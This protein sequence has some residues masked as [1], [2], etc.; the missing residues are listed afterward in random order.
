M[1]QPRNKFTVLLSWDVTSKTQFP[2]LFNSWSNRNPAYLCLLGLQDS[3]EAKMKAGLGKQQQLPFITTQLVPTQ[4]F[5][6]TH[7]SGK[8][9]WDQ[10]CSTLKLFK[11][12]SG[13]KQFEED[14][15]C[16]HSWTR[17]VSSDILWESVTGIAFVICSIKPSSPTID[18][19]AFEPRLTLVAPLWLDFCFART[20]LRSQTSIS[21]L[22]V[23]KCLQNTNTDNW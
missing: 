21:L 3:F 12:Y 16:C 19:L 17:I 23:P 9:V 2:W 14:F 10:T 4:T 22:F 15:C 8:N 11:T 20:A 13:A 7:C 5:S 18:W 6:A 1:I